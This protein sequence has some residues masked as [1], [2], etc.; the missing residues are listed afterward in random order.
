M[1][2]ITDTTNL[3]VVDQY[4]AVFGNHKLTARMLQTAMYIHMEYLS[5][6][7]RKEDVLSDPGLEYLF[8][9]LPKGLDRGAVSA[10]WVK[11]SPL[12]PVFKGNGVFEMLRWANK[13]KWDLNGADDTYWA[14]CQP[15]VTAKPKIP[16]IERAIEALV[17]AAA[18]I[19]KTDG[20]KHPVDSL[21]ETI[22]GYMPE[23]GK[24]IRE[25]MS[26]D[27]VEKFVKRVADYKKLNGE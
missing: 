9:N 16:E 6:I 23:M 17:L 5:N 26:T 20:V 2:Y 25:A 27:K 13:G 1:S 21:V 10:W 8:N 12:R 22:N 7:E 15:E 11:F 14:D 19:A 4:K 24:A 3:S 18:K